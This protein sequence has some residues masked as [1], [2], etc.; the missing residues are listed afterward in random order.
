[1][2]LPVKCGMAHSKGA[3]KSRERSPHRFHRSK[4]DPAYASRKFTREGASAISTVTKVGV[5]PRMSFGAGARPNDGNGSSL[6]GR[7]GTVSEN[8]R[9]VSHSGF[10]SAAVQRNRLKS[11]TNR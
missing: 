8:I 11:M 9:A 4:A 1:M 3:R 5:S 6:V 7:V 10:A 2:F